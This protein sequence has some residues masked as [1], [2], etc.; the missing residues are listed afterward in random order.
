M[1][2]LK[3]KTKGLATLEASLTLPVILLMIFFIFEMIKVNSVRNAMDSMVTEAVL[4]FVSTKKTTNFDAIIEK[5]KPIFVLKEKIRYYFAIYDS[6]DVMCSAA[7]YGNEDVYW[8]DKTGKK[9]SS[10]PFLGQNN[11]FLARTGDIALVDGT[12]PE[13]GFTTSTNLTLRNK[14]FVLTI[15]CDHAFSSN[16]IGKAFAGGSNCKGLPEG[17]TKFLMWGRGVGVTN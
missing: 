7:P 12:K 8:P 15:V 2:F 10:A 13:L 9:E 14:V 4:D 3:S 17:Q 5:H 11:T 1:P 6:L 16:F